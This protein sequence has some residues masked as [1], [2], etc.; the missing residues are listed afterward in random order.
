MLIQ[1]SVLGLDGFVSNVPQ[2][3]ISL[4]FKMSYPLQSFNCSGTASA[5]YLNFKEKAHP[6]EDSK[7]CILDRDNGVK[8]DSVKVE[9][10]V[11]NTACLPFTLLLFFEYLIH[12]STT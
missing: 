4:Q 12:D 3:S 2:C 8:E 11:C 9:E 6:H 1:C 5:L 7:V 10:E